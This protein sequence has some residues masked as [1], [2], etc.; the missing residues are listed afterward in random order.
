[1]NSPATERYLLDPSITLI[2]ENNRIRQTALRNVADSQRALQV[3]GAIVSRFRLALHRIL[4][5][6]PNDSEILA[7]CEEAICGPSN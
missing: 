4:L 7:I 6:A 1:M 2:E 3:K 5:L